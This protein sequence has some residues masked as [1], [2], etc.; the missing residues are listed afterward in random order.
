V[1]RGRKYSPKLLQRNPKER[2]CCC[3]EKKEHQYAMKKMMLYF[4]GLKTWIVYVLIP[5]GFVVKREQFK[6]LI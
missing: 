1:F 5:T 3:P 4:F 6:A 2:E